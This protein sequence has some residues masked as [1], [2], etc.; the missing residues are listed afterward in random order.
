[1]QRKQGFSMIE[2]LIVI[3]ILGILAAVVVPSFLNVKTKGFD[4]AAKADLRN[5]I[6][7]QEN[8]FSEQ[9]AYTDVTISAGGGGDLNGDGTEDFRASQGVS[10][11]ATA[12][13]DGFQ[14]TATH[15]GSPN[16]WCVNSSSG[17]SGAAGSIRKATSC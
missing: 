1:M 15:F 16:I 17:A 3:V 11:G 12:Y 8:Y 14:I 9:Q 10:L 5:M 6:A 2:L 13:T 7:S 4:S